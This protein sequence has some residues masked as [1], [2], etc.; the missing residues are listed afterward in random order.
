MQ[1]RE[2]IAKPNGPC[3]CAG[4]RQGMAENENGIGASVETRCRSARAL[5][6][7]NGL[8]RGSKRGAVERYYNSRGSIER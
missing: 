4:S 7:P 8:E 6:D 5:V 2:G 1:G 3:R